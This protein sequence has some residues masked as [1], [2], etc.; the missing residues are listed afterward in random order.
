MPPWLPSGL[1]RITTCYSTVQPHATLR[2]G[3]G[4]SHQDHPSCNR[5]IFHRLPDLSGGISWAAVATHSNHHFI[6]ERLRTRHLSTC[7]STG[8]YIFYCGPPPAVTGGHKPTMALRYRCSI[9]LS[10]DGIHSPS[11]FP[12]ANGTCRLLGLSI[13]LIIRYTHSSQMPSFLSRSKNPQTAGRTWLAPCTMLSDNGAGR[14]QCVIIGP[15][16]LY[17]QAWRVSLLGA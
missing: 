17:H 1:S 6:S 16:S 13:R 5:M 3:S 14:S 10:N 9:I 2:A 12:A 15:A 11:C 7:R 8:L 4:L